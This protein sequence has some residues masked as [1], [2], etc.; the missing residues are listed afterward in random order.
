MKE[1][2]KIEKFMTAMPHTV[3]AGVSIKTAHNLMRKYGIRHLPVQT[4]GNLVGVITDRDLKLSASFEGAEKMMV[5]DAMT[6]DP[7]TVAVG[8]PLDDVLGEMVAHKYG[9]AVVVQ[10]NGKVVGIFTAI[11]GLSALSGLLN[12]RYKKPA[13]A[14]RRAK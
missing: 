13:T 6:G 3:N 8:T 10:D 12:A 1:L 14:E 4:G 9:C 5:D 7:Y 2:P 11:D